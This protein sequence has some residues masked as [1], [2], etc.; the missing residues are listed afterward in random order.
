[1]PKSSSF[2]VPGVISFLIALVFFGLEITGL[3]SSYNFMQQTLAPVQ[4]GI[5]LFQDGTNSSSGSGSYGKLIVSTE[6]CYPRSNNDL[7]NMLGLWYQVYLYFYIATVIFFIASV[8]K[9]C[10][11]G[12]RGVES[13]FSR[14]YQSITQGLPGYNK[15]LVL[16]IRL[17]TG[18][19]NWT[20]F[21]EYENEQVSSYDEA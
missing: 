7:V 10:Y 6:I 11:A 16:L 1:M 9:S 3:Y 17:V 8:V 18:K 12:F 20:N 5:I 14:P 15:G 13:A 19:S 4:R 21:T 2:K